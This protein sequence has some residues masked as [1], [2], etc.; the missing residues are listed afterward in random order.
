MNGHETHAIERV[1][2]DFTNGKLA[3]MIPC[4]VEG[5]LPEASPLEFPMDAKLLD[6]QPA[7][8]DVQSNEAIDSAT[9]NSGI[10]VLVLDV[11]RDR[12]PSICLV[13]PLR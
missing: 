11:D 9:C 6:V 1:Q 7:F 5:C 12:F 10:T 2:S 4:F 3:C 8:G 13:E